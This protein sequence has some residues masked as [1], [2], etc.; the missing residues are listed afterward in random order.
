[1]TN[2]VIASMI[3]ITIDNLPETSYSY[4]VYSGSNS[5]R[6]IITIFLNDVCYL[7]SYFNQTT[8]VTTFNFTSLYSIGALTLVGPNVPSTPAL[9]L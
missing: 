8:G 2:S 6:L 5:G 9:S 3:S 4:Q 7:T 1:M